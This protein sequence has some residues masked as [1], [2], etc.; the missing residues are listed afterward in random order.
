MFKQLIVA[1]FAVIQL[2]CVPAALAT[3]TVQITDVR[4]E[5][6]FA[7]E[8]MQYDCNDIQPPPI[9]LAPLF[10]DYGYWGMY[11]GYALYIDNQI[12]PYLDQ[13]LV[14]SVIAHELTHYLDHVRQGEV[15]FSDKAHMCAT[16]WNAWR[17]GNAYV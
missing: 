6:E 5:L 13:D 17:V 14:R 7:C 10:W 9:V 11:D 3:P 15:L 2:I 16:E 8:I 4:A 12:V 1:A